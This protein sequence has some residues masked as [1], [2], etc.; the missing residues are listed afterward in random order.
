[1]DSIVQSIGAIPSQVPQIMNSF[2]LTQ[3]NNKKMLL[4]SEE[5]LHQATQLKYGW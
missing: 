2:E 4:R 3:Q 1:M 5:H